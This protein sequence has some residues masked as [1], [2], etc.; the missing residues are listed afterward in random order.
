ML[1]D[2]ESKTLDALPGWAGELV[3]A[4]QVARLGFLDDRDCPRVLPITY[5]VWDNAI[6]SAVDRKPKK[7]GEPAR[8][9]YLRRRPEAAVVID[10]YS[11]DWR[12]LAWVQIL[13]AVTIEAIADAPQAAAALVAKYRPYADEPPPGPLLRL[14]PERIL[15]WSAGIG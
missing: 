3:H 5:A 7:P 10:R 14:A 4:E 8:I 12:R 9:R 11:S 13:G 15:C 2:V 6:W 1:A